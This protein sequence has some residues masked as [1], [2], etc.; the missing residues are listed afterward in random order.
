MT[1]IFLSGLLS[2]LSQSIPDLLDCGV[3]VLVAFGG[4]VKLQEAMWEC[5]VD[6]QFHVFLQFRESLSQAATV[7]VEGV[8]VA[9]EY[10]GG[11]ELL[12]YLL[13]ALDGT[14]ERVE[15]RLK[16]FILDVGLQAYL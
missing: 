2:Q 1:N 15:I 14:E 10:P 3:A 13:W 6:R 11:R 5:I 9:N 16:L 12:E 4:I 8:R 7:V